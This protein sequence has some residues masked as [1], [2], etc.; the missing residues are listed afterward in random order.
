M[1]KRDGSDA[2]NPPRKKLT[3]SRET[4]TRLGD[5]AMRRVA[6]GTQYTF[7]QCTNEYTDCFTCPQPTCITC[8]SDCI[9]CQT[10]VTCQTCVSCP[11][12]S[13]CDPTCITCPNPSC[14]CTFPC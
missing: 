9:P 13:V 2:G 4:L 11:G 7:P 12:D 10:E 5:T 6:G 14:V 8:E 3:I 1:G